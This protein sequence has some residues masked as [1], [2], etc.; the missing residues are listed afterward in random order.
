MLRKLCSEQPKQWNRYI[1]PLLFA[2]REV[3]QA[4]TGFS[5]FELIYGKTVRGPMQIVK[6]LWTED[7]SETEVKNSYKYIFDLRERIQET[8]KLAQEN[9]GKAQLRNKHYYDKKTRE[10]KLNIGDEVVIL[11]PQD[12]NKLLMKWKGPYKVVTTNYENNYGVD[13]N[14]KIRKYHIKL[15]KKFIR[16]EEL[17][18]EIEGINTLAIIIDDQE[19]EEEERLPTLGYEVKEGIKDIK[20]EKTILKEQKKDLTL[21]W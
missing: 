16:R 2:Y 12:H 5:P 4:S 21:K 20:I 10:R 6:E 14:G 11:L 13:V 17:K 7:I 3:P 8:L 15:L 1:A 9:L 19:E 18:N